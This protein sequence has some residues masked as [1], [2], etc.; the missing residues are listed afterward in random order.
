MEQEPLIKDLVAFV[1]GLARKVQLGCQDAPTW[2]LDFHMVVARASR[3]ER[4]NDGRK[5]PAAT[6][7][8]ELMT[9]QPVADAVI[10][11]MFIGVPKLDKC[12]V[13]G[14][15]VRREYETGYGDPDP[16]RCVGGKIL[17]EWRAMIVLR[18]FS[19]RD[20]QLIHILACR[21]QL[22]SRLCADG[23]RFE[24]TCRFNRRYRQKCSED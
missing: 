10:R 17:F 13:D 18:S 19:L 23:I 14:F 9:T 11:A 12:P 5:P 6:L 3:I 4:W 7:I 20:S 24:N 21:R 16:V 22:E 2:L 15:A 8:G 1:Q